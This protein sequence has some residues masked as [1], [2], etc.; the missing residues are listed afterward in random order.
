MTPSPPMTE[1]V[2]EEGGVEKIRIPSVN[3]VGKQDKC[4]GS[5][6]TMH[7]EYFE[8]ES[9][10]LVEFDVGHRL[11]SELADLMNIA[12]EILTLYLKTT[13]VRW[14]LSKD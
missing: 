6:K 3:V 2:Y 8:E 9:A 5:G 4:Y 14:I 11:P 12:R 1:L 13:G 10:K 7:K